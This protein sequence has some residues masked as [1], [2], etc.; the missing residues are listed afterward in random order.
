MPPPP[1]QPQSGPLPVPRTFGRSGMAL[2]GTPTDGFPYVPTDTV[3]PI[4][5]RSPGLASDTNPTVTRP[6]EWALRGNDNNAGDNEEEPLITPW[7]VFN[8]FARRAEE[9]ERFAVY[10][11]G[12]LT[13]AE[14]EAGVNPWFGQCSSMRQ[15]AT[16]GLHLFGGEAYINNFRWQGPPKGVLIGTQPVIVN[17]QPDPAT[18]GRTR[19]RISNAS[20][21]SANGLKGYYLRVTRAGTRASFEVPIDGNDLDGG[22]GPNGYLYTS[23]G[24]FTAGDGTY[25]NTDTFEVIYRAAEFIPT[26]RASGDAGVGGADG[27]T[28]TGWGTANWQGRLVNQV[29]PVPT[30]AFLGFE[31]LN[32]FGAHGISFD[33]CAFYH[34]F[35]AFNSS[36]DFRGCIIDAQITTQFVN[37]RI[38][39]V[40][41]TLY[42]EPQAY[43]GFVDDSVLAGEVAPL[44]PDVGGP[45]LYAFSQSGS[46]GGIIQR[47]GLFRLPKGL[48]VEGGIVV[49]D[50][51]RFVM[52]PDGVAHTLHCRDTIGAGTGA[53]HV[54]GDS[55]AIIDP[56]DYSTKNVTADMKVGEGAAINLGT[57]S[58]QFSEVGGWAG[59]FDRSLEV[60]GGG[61]PTSDRS[62]IRTSVTFS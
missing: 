7:G 2:S 52:A 17:I 46:A 62:A 32:A 36:L 15:Y 12:G 45:S 28:L 42:T 38:N 34:S 47:G 61:K 44:N 39:E 14:V 24:N 16:R 22:V 60:N 5:L 3:T 43:N 56:S 10:M 33:R 51:G 40:A 57:G 11:A 18:N 35:N 49:T 54:K 9:G 6:L 1:Y 4:Y 58:G 29:N 27:I 13:D 31:N 8:R 53:L 41:A 55:V 37:C 25:E 50:G 23:H 59:N 30:F 26:S 19:W 20:S 48:V 21:F